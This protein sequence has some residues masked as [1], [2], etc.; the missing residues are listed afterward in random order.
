MSQESRPVLTESALLATRVAL[1]GYF[2]L[3]GF[4]KVQGELSGGLGSFARGPAFTGLQP[5][6]LPD[7]MAAPY[8]YALPW[9]EVLFG[10]TLAAG[11]FSRISAAAIFGMLASF[12]VALMTANGISGGS[13]GPFHA[14]VILAAAALVYLARGGGPLSV[15]ALIDRVRGERAATGRSSAS[16]A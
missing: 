12:T 7:L 13:P 4:G 8:G 3:A 1:G 2:L 9:I 10:A 11:L 15:D 16:P 5:S 6:W 14:N